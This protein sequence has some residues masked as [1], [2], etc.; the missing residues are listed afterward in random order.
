MNLQVPVSWLREYLKTDVAAK[1]IA[2]HLTTCGPSV[3]RQQKKQ[4]D[5]IFDVEVTSNRPDAFSIYGLARETHAIL[6]NNGEKSQLI[7][8]SGLNQSLEPDTL[9]RLSLDVTIANKNLC[10]RF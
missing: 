6:T 10:P 1:T 7:L 2:S 4:E 8:P 9:N 5:I 3:E